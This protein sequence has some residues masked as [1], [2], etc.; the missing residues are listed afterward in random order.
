MLQELAVRDTAH[1]MET[2]LAWYLDAFPEIELAKNLVHQP[3]AHPG[4]PLEGDLNPSPP[5]SPAPRVPI[6]D[7]AFMQNMR[8]FRPEMRDMIYGEMRSPR[9]LVIKRV[10]RV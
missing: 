5:P 2:P 8:T 9:I 6:N 4:F 3:P 7:E 10:L 1:R